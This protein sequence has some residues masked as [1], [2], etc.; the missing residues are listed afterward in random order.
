MRRAQR[1]WAAG[2]GL[3]AVAGVLVTGLAPGT[4]VSGRSD[5]STVAV[6]VLPVLLVL[7]MRPRLRR[8]LAALLLAAGVVAGVAGITGLTGA[9]APDFSFATIGIWFFIGTVSA[10]MPLPTAAALVAGGAGLLTV[11]RRW[12]VV[13]LVLAALV[14]A[15]FALTR[16]AGPAAR[17]DDG[18]FWLDRGAL[19][20]GAALG[21]VA[22]VL[23]VLGA[24]SPWVLTGPEP[25]SSAGPARSTRPR[26]RMLRVGGA[27]VLVG[28][29]AAL[30]VAGWRTWGDRLV[31]ADVFPDRVLAA[32]LAGELGEPGPSAAVS[33][34]DLD[35]VLSLDCTGGGRVTDLT[36]AGRLENL[37]TLD[38]AGDAVA[39]LGPLRGL[40]K[41]ARLTLTNDRVTDL[42]PLAGLPALS[43]LGLTGNAVGDL[44]PLAHVPTLRH[45]GL[46]GNRITDVTP[47]ASL[48]GLSDLDLSRNTVADIAPLAGLAQLDQLQLTDN[49]IGDLGPL[50]SDRALRVL[51][52][53][54]NQV[55][56]VEGLRGAA[57]LA[58]L[59]IG[60]NP[61]TDLSPLLELPALT[62]VD[63]EGVPPTIPGLAELRARGVYVG[64]LAG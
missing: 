58:E 7:G 14:A 4:G 46:A 20:S 51:R 39:D 12:L 63:L 49:R 37:A 56:D 30:A 43:D 8:P 25:R 15:W 45:L 47:L 3:A 42:S 2:A 22:V 31:L 40:P 36:G 5:A 9:D 35:H 19:A 13:S 64:G 21:L 33:S 16:L 41:L 48:T 61:L 57:N 55:A 62:G 10:V 32:C 28:A 24:V 23:L 27:L 26:R 44:R 11:R 18:G 52:V 60:R 6:G 50:T 38:L 1:V 29:V 59:W 54:G 53:D 17:A 34:A